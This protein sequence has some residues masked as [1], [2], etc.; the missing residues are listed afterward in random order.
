MIIQG[1][2]TV[3]NIVEFMIYVAYLIWPVAALGYTTNRFQKSLASWYRV[4]EVLDYPIEIH[5]KIKNKYISLGDIEF[6]NVWF[7]YPDTDEYIIKNLSLKIKAGSKTAIVGRT[8]SGKTT[9][10]Q[11]IPRLFDAT[12]GRIL[13]DGTDIRE[14]KVKDLRNSIGFVPQ[15][16][17]LFSDTIGQN[18]SFGIENATK[19]HIEKVAELAMVKENILQFKNK[20]KT[21]LGERGIT[22][23]GGQKQ[24]TA[25]ARALIKSPKI[26]IFDDSLSAI[27][28]KTENS[29]LKNLK[30]ELG[31]ITTIT[32]SHRISTIKNADTILYLENGQIIEEGTHEELVEL[33]GHYNAIYKKQILEQEL[34][35]I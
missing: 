31:N 16:T 24:R 23:S 30:K 12:K 11:L 9:L 29:I 7:K 3:G 28:T 35:Q 19:Q 17:F 22:L 25:I 20:F 33:N 26:L 2:L 4:K 18:I 32:I 14:I 5:K 6:K 1:S 15:G 10:I 13:I 34:E 8:G 27:D 21:I